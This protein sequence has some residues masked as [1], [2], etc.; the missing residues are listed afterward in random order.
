MPSPTAPLIIVADDDSNVLKVLQFHL[1]NWGY[2][3]SLASDKS[4]L[5]RAIGVERP[6]A[7]LLD[8]RFGEHDGVE[9]LQGL[10]A[11]D[12]NLVVVMMTAFGSID[13]AV[14]A[15]KIGAFDYVTKPPDLNRLKILVEEAVKQSVQRQ[16]AAAVGT[17]S[18]AGGTQDPQAGPSLI[19]VSEAASRLRAQ[20]EAVAP[21]EASVLILG[22]SGTGKEVVARTLHSLSL[23]A[24]H[25][26]IALNMAALPRDLVESTLFG[27]E[28]GA[29][30]GADQ[31]QP[32][33]VEAADKGTLFL[34]EIGE[35]EIGLQAKLLRF[36]QERNFQR[37][38]SSKA[39]AVDVRI[40]A[41][42]NRDPLVQVRNG[43]LREDLYYRLNVVPIVVPQL[44]ERR[45]DVEVL[46]NL[47][48]TRVAAR[49]GKP[50]MAFSP[51]ALELL[52]RHDWPGN[53]RQ[54]ENLVERLVIFNQGSVIGSAAI[55][56][57][58]ANPQAASKPITA[59]DS[60]SLLDGSGTSELSKGMDLIE[61]AAIED[62]LRSVRGNVRDAAKVLGIGQATVY[63]KIKKYGIRLD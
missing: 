21:T 29:F 11:G 35:M 34:D 52:K 14:S 51:E 40:I 42:T 18:R 28:K 63:R 4:S 20:I 23:R 8:I 10:L 15:M 44:R 50:E 54:L 22:E 39:R 36:L 58:I 60:D 62:A 32:G 31:A 7:M 6:A 1:T 48:L 55:P 12:P 25:P 19:G 37:V 26:F 13:S 45:D 9:L 24:S 61:K 56:P 46:A 27:Y 17:A 41:A 38:G 30:T 49:Y 3:T 5:F 43:Q 33:S 2:R 59:A 47:F 57:E 53:V 16:S